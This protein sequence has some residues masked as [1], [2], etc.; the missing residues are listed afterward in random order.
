MI[1]DARTLPTDTVVDAE[2]C[3]IGAGAAGISLALEF[4]ASAFR[5]AV[6]ESGGLEYE[7]ETQKLYDGR[8]IGRPFPG[9][10]TDRLRFFGGTTN[11]WGGWCMPF[12][13]I[14]FEIRDGLPNHGWPFSKTYLEPWYDR[15]QTVCR[16]GPYDYRPASWG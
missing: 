16:L 12:D 8:S 10:T 3:I 5:V 9:L 7:P 13:E 11:H 2:V 14:D 1:V 4:S 6:L 15:A